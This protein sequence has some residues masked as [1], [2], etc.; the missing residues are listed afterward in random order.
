M[1]YLSDKLAE[2]QYTK[3]V[4]I[5]V[6]PRWLHPDPE[7]DQIYGAFDPDKKEDKQ[8]IE[9]MQELGLLQ[10]LLVRRHPVFPNEYII[11]SGHRR[12]CAAKAAGIE[13]VEVLVMNTNTPE[14]IA[15]AKLAISVSNHT[16]N[17]SNPA[18]QAREI[19]HA[20]KYIQELRKL[21]PDKY[22]GKRTREVIAEELGISE[23]TVARTQRITKK[24]DETTKKEFDSGKI[25]QTEAIRRVDE[26]VTTA[27]I[28]PLPGQLP[29]IQDD[30]DIMTIPSPV[31]LEDSAPPS[32]KGI[33]TINQLVRITERI[34][35]F[36]LIASDTNV[37][38]LI[39]SL[40]KAVARAEK[41]SNEGRHK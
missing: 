20:E 23:K 10:P 9:E 24:A 4:M 39:N 38:N 40:E 2:N 33:K 31:I 27:K 26:A 14:E 1:S 25:T 3:S 6:E 30:L 34:E 12:F 15:Q 41:T 28:E 11:V 16:R 8:L 17:R 32:T 18:L 29:M 19:E 36:P 35:M 5:M 37:K 7:N 22:K 13:R 21:N